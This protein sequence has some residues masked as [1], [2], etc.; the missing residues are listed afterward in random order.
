MQMV[1]A[2]TWHP[3][4]AFFFCFLVLLVLD[5]HWA[6]VLVRLCRSRTRRLAGT[7]RPLWSY[8]CFSGWIRWLRIFRFRD[9]KVA[10]L[11]HRSEYLSTTSIK[12]S[13]AKKNT[14]HSNQAHTHEAYQAYNHQRVRR[15]QLHQRRKTGLSCKLCNMMD[16]SPFLA[17]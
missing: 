8:E 3:A 13:S 12:L 9:G 16:N 14:D 6:G 15:T 7:I 5:L 11:E 4:S 1:S 2:E 10:W 17:F